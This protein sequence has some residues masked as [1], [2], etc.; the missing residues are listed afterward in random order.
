M[1]IDYTEISERIA[2]RYGH[3]FDF[4]KEENRYVTLDLI[5]SLEDFDR[6][7]P[8]LSGIVE[9]THSDEEFKKAMQLLLGWSWHT[10]D[11]LSR[12]WKRLMDD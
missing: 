4:V 5:E 6:L 9:C 1:A 8:A 10:A 12:L 7:R 3:L 11:H 2:T